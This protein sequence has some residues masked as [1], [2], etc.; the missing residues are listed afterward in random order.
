VERIAP[1]VPP[2]PADLATLQTFIDRILG[3]EFVGEAEAIQVKENGLALKHM[4]DAQQ[5][6][7]DLIALEVAEGILFE[8]QR[9][10]RDVW[11]NFPTKVG[12]LIAAELGVD[13]DRLIEAL[14]THVHQQCADLGEPDAD[15]RG[16]GGKT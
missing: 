16:Q 3:G 15:F 2:K 8:T 14:T 12:P 6:A 1:D 5:K 10:Q 4:L 11:L 7:G 13:A 9:A